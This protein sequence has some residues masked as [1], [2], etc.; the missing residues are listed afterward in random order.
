VSFFDTPA[1][2]ETI[3]QRHTGYLGVRFH[4]HGDSWVELALPWREDLVG[5][6][7][8]GVL[9]SGPII[10]LLDT[11]AGMAV[12]ARNGAR[13]KTAT[14]DLRIDYM[15]AARKGLTVIARAECY[16]I[17]R[18]VAFVTGLAHEGDPQHPV[19][20]AAG[21]FMLMNSPA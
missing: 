18:T 16:R 19:A 6:P 14:L 10:S 17:T 1:A 8:S 4:A 2:L 9:A 13:I 7:A 11:A 12:T 21:S 5:V 3:S 20:H 15:R